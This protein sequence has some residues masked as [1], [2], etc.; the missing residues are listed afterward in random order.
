M[1]NN[2]NEINIE[3]VNPEILKKLYEQNERNKKYSSEYQKLHRDKSHMST[4]KYYEKMKDNLEFIEK[5]K[6]RQRVY[7]QRKKEKLKNELKE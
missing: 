5:R 1:A 7:Y 2:N 4:K 6:K 3:N